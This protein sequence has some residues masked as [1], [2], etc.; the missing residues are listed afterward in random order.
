MKMEIQKMIDALNQQ[1]QAI[2]GETVH[3][4]DFDQ[5]QSDLAEAARILIGL[6]ERDRL[7]ERL[8]ADFKSDIARMALAVS[9]AKGEAGTGELVEKL[10]SSQDAS[11]DD[12]FHL[13]KMVREQ[14]NHCFPAAPQSKVS[15]RLASSQAKVSEFKSGVPGRS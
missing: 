6:S 7:C 12:L 15:G 4:M 8:L 11:L 10:I 14:F 9:R 2:E 13:R 5:L 1:C 3:Q